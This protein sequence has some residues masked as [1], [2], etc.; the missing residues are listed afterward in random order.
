MKNLCGYH[1]NL[2][3]VGDPDQTIYTWRG[4]SVNS[5]PDFDKNFPGVQTIMMMKNYRSS[6]EILD[7]ANSLVSKNVNRMKKD[8]IPMLP[9]RNKVVVHHA[10]NPRKEAQWIISQIRHLNENGVNPGDV[11]ILYRA[12]YV[13]RVIEEE[14]IKEKMPYM[15]YSGVQFFERMEIKDAL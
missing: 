8:L 6:P 4:A 12:H 7:V 1:N 14:M 2:F 9:H 15:I 5:L 3:V 13:T 11:T 10:E